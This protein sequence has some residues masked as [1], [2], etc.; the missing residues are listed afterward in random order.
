MDIFKELFKFFINK[1]YSFTSRFIGLIII[2]MVL[3]SI[4]NLL[5]FSFYYSTNQK[6]T[7]IKNIETLKKECINNQR[8]MSILEETENEIIN[9]KNLVENFFDLFS[10]EPFK[11][12]AKNNYDLPDTIFITKY[13]TIKIFQNSY[14]IPWY[15]SQLD[16]SN[17][18]KKKFS[19]SVKREQPVQIANNITIDSTTNNSEKVISSTENEQLRYRSK[20]WHTVTSSYLLILLMFILPIIPF[21]E[22]K[23][24]WSMMLG[25]IFIMIFNAGFIW[26]NQF[27][28]GLIPVILNRPWINYIVN[29]SLHSGFWS[30]IIIISNKKKKNNAT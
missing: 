27:L 28:L 12:E 7:Q 17:L 4:N 10:K 22:K 18:I 5:G 15:L 1:K 20:L 2:L 6:I 29:F 9:R 30:I 21:T 19:D 3:F 25:M 8:L 16:S 14:N 13:D 26:L 23:F 11:G 24:S